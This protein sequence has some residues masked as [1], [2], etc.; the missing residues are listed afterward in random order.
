MKIRFADRYEVQKFDTLN[1]AVFR[2]MPEGYDNSKG[3]LRTAEDGRALKHTG[4]Y[5]GRCEHAVEKAA[6]LLLADGLDASEARDLAALLTDIRA[7]V[8]KA[9]REIGEAT[10]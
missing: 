3:R 8:E 9:A 1:W 2:V 5:Y 6:E 4:T 7:E 10:S